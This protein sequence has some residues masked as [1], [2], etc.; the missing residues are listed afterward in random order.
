[1]KQV[2]SWIWPVGY[3]LLTFVVAQLLSHVWFFATPWTAARRA[4][5]SFAMSFIW[6]F[7]FLSFSFFC[8]NAFSQSTDTKFKFLSIESLMLSNHFILRHALLLLP[9]IFPSIKVFFTEWALHIRWP[10]YRSFTFN[11]SP[12]NEYQDWFP[13]GLTGLISLLS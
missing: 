9:S 7:A 13:L 2:V 5:L 10:K 4:P 6:E 8:H 11:I 3:S 12:S 1:M